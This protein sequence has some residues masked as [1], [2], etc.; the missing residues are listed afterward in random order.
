[1]KCRDDVIS[2]V[3]INYYSTRLIRRYEEEFNEIDNVELIVVDNSNDFEAVYCS[4][5]IIKPNENLGFGKA[6]N[7]GVAKARGKAVVFSNPDCDLNESQLQKLYE[8]FEL[9]QQW[10]LAPQI[11]DNIGVQSTLI[12]SKIPGILYRRIPTCEVNGL[13]ERLYVSGACF[14]IEK[15]FFSAV[16]GF[17]EDIFLYG[18]DLDFCLRAKEIGGT[19]LVTSNCIVEHTGG[20]SSSSNKTIVQKLKR[21]NN[22]IK[23]HYIFFRRNFGPVTSIVNAVYLASGV[24]F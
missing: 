7:L 18:E 2:I 21:L 24:K 4:T 22:S 19:V 16:G 23:G 15:T 14:M 6:C 1:M 12:P 17:S 3:V 9:G 10:I 5:Q 13:E 8:T 20:D 11:V